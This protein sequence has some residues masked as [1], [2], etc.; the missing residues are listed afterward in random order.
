MLVEA[1]QIV[2][3]NEHFCLNTLY[4]EWFAIWI[5][6][7]YQRVSGS[8]FPVDLQMKLTLSPSDTSM[9]LRLVSM[10]FALSAS[11]N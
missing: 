9:F 4:S 7:L 10:I 2:Q 5:P 1:E 3:W 11:E 6:T 8:G